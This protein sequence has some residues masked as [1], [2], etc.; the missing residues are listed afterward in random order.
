MEKKEWIEAY[1]LQVMA[2]YDAE[3]YDHNCSYGWKEDGIY[4]GPEDA[5]LLAE[6]AWNRLVELGLKTMWDAKG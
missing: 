5:Y 2:A 3:R 1:A 4:L 6:R